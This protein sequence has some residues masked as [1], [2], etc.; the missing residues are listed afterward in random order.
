MARD[1]MATKLCYYLRLHYI[2]GTID[3]VWFKPLKLQSSAGEDS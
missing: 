1:E 3:L 2:F